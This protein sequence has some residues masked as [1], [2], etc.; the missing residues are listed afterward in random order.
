MVDRPFLTDCLW[1]AG[2]RNGEGGTEDAYAMGELAKAWTRGLQSPRPSKLNSSR[3]LLQ[4]VVT[5]KHFAVNT[6]ENT[7]P[8]TRTSFD[9]NAS[10]GV[11]NFALADY[12]L[13]PFQ[14]AIQDADA[15]G[16][17]CSY[18][19]VLNLPTCLSPLLRNARKQW[20]FQGYVTSDTDSIA[21][22]TSDHH[23]TSS[24]EQATALGLTDGQ[25]DVNSG[26]TYSGNILGALKDRTENL[27]IADVDRALFNSFKQRFD[28]GLFDPKE[29]YDWPGK[30]DIGTDVTS[31]AL[32]KV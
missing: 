28:L 6:L 18:N 12:Y 30:E 19:A 15:R 5:L 17:M 8:W 13:R 24:P 3:E 16:I 10:F 29:A 22:A 25:C 2:G 4:V 21:S 23:Y 7:D 14:A 27:T 1:S 20:G 31:Q 9:A 26:A 32:E 11:G